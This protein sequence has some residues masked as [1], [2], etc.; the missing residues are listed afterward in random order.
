MWIQVNIHDAWF[1]CE[2]SSTFN[3][4]VVVQSQQRNISTI[5]KL[6]EILKI[7]NWPLV[8]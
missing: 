4:L 6:I 1:C 7:L 5:I 8:A 3:G 2:I